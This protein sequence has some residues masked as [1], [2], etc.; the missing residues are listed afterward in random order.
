MPNDE[1]FAYH[2]A[3]HAVAMWTLGLGVKVVS[4]DPKGKLRGY[5]EPARRYHE[6]PHDNTH[7]WLAINRICGWC[8]SRRSGA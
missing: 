8:R 4:I 2:E 7:C 1:L 5:A 6:P 3:G